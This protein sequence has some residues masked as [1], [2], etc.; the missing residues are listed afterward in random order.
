MRR[1]TGQVRAE[2]ALIN[3]WSAVNRAGEFG[4]WLIG[5]VTRAPAL[6]VAAFSLSACASNF[7]DQVEPCTTAADLP[8]ITA[9]PQGIESFEL[10]V[11]IYNVEGL[12]GPLARIADPSSNKS[13]TSWHVF[14]PRGGLPISSCFR[15]PSPNARRRSANARAIAIEWQDRWRAIA[16]PP[17]ARTFLQFL[18]KRVGFSKASAPEKCWGVAYSFSAN[19]L[20][21]RLITSRFR[22]TPALDST[23]FQTKG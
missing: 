4:S 3:A 20:S 13:V 18:I 14:V 11:L 1:R 10:S 15:K 23:V 6:F 9:D 22:A 16:A 8:V 7:E 21:R 2:S 19:S 12:P 5:Q 17:Q